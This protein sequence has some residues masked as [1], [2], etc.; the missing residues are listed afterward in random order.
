MIRKVIRIFAVLILL[1]GA[2]LLA[3]PFVNEV[4]YD[5][6]AQNVIEDYEEKTKD[7]YL[8]ELRALMEEYNEDLFENGQADFKDA[9]SYQPASFDLTEWGF[10]DIRG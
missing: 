9:W 1:A 10:E 5:R 4:A 3:F 7:L 6:Q 8:P 2:A